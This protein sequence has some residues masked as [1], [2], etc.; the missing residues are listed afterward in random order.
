MHKIGR[1]LG[2]FGTL[3]T[4]WFYGISTSLEAY[5]FSVFG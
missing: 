3:K 1:G 4:L 2:A 5:K